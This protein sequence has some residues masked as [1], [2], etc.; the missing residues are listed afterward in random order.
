MTKTGINDVQLAWIFGKDS[1]P[2]IVRR[3]RKEEVEEVEEDEGEEEQQEE[4]EELG[5]WRGGG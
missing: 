1:L 5:V 3:R 2:F 4:E